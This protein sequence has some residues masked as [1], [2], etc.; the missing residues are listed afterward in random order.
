MQGRQAHRY[1][2]CNYE[3]QYT[4]WSRKIFFII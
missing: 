1:C 2:L 3:K 4:F